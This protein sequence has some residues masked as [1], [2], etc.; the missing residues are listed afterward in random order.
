MATL[1]L[2]ESDIKGSVKITCSEATQLLKK[3]KVRKVW[4]RPSG[5]LSKDPDNDPAYV[6]MKEED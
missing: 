6:W 3:D 5:I 2:I 4:Y 1:E